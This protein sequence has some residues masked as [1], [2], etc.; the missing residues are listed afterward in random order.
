MIVVE[1]RMEVAQPSVQLRGLVR[2][3]VGYESSGL[4]TGVHL[5]LP[6]RNATLVFSFDEPM[7]MVSVSAGLERTHESRNV[8]GGL[9]SQA[10]EIH[11]NGSHHGIQVEISPLA[12]PMLFG[13]SAAEF[14][15]DLVDVGDMS[16][17]GGRSLGDR[18]AST[19]DWA[20]RFRVLDRAL[21]HQLKVNSGRVHATS[22]PEVA[23]A[24]AMLVRTN[25]TL[26]VREMAGQLGWSQRHLTAKFNDEFGMAPKAAARIL[27]FEQASRLGM[28]PNPRT[29]AEIAAATGFSDQAHLTREWADICRC[30]PNVW[31][32]REGLTDSDVQS[33]DQ[34]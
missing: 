31:R 7:K 19:Q 14:A 30:S 27:R 5:G 21:T 12:V 32:Q 17:V 16:W 26:R 25:G 18:L 11:H 2:R 23:Q 4:P 20:E 10:L 3:Y 6:S 15:N 13:F 1:S 28:A 22:R 29:W 8:I 34:A 9:H 33:P 24:W